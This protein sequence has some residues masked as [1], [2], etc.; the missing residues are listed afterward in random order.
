MLNDEVTEFLEGGRLIHFGTRNAD[1]E[2]TGV[3]GSAL[4][5]EP[6][7]AHIVAFLPVCGSEETLANLHANGQAALC[8]GRPV[9]E[10]ACQVKGVFVSVRAA[11]AHERDVIETQLEVGLR[12]L[13]EIGIPRQLYTGHPHWPSVAVRLRVTEVFNQTPGPGAG[14]PIT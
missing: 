10:R 13:E 2:A 6:D 12:Q 7:R 14:A 11:D 5:V 3:Q 9:D 8:A 4:V 1:L